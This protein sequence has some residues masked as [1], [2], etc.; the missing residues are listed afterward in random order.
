MGTILDKANILTKTKLDSLDTKQYPNQAF[1]TTDE[2]DGELDENLAIQ[3]AESERQKSKNLFKVNNN[4]G[5]SFTLNGVTATINDDYTITLNGT[6]SW[7]SYFNMFAGIS[8]GATL[9]G[10]YPKLFL[11]K[12]KKYT[13]VLKY[14]SGSYSGVGTDEQIVGAVFR[15][16]DGTAVVTGIDLHISTNGEVLNS[17]KTG[18]DYLNN[19]YFRATN[20][21]TYNNYTIGLMICE[22]TDADFQSWNGAIF[23]EK[24]L[25]KT[26]EKRELKYKNA[27]S[28]SIQDSTLDTLADYFSL[29]ETSPDTIYKCHIGFLENSKFKD[30]VGTPELSSNYV[31]CY[32]KKVVD[33]YAYRCNCYELFA[34]A[35][36]GTKIAKGYIY[37]NSNDTVVFTG[38]T[39]IGG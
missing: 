11:D 14:I 22:G 32:I 3:F 8:I 20:G 38:W 29:F 13:F 7:H 10:D 25:N 16:T 4:V 18:L 5:Y 19:G 33:G 21:I 34:M 37:L 39:R 26:L 35:D 15:K 12:N 36:Y 27:G 1:I 31:H 9:S 28:I 30:L 24:Q 23:H 17:T 6:C 2:R